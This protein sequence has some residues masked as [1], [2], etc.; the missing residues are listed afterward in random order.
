LLTDFRIADLLKARRDYAGALDASRE[1]LAVARRLSEK[2]PNNANWQI[3]IA[4]SQFNVGEAL[5]ALGDPKDALPAYQEA[6]ELTVALAD[7]EPGT[8]FWK[9][10]LWSM[11]RALGDTFA[12]LG[13]PS[14]ALRT[15][16]ESRAVAA[17]LI[18]LDPTNVAYQGDLKSSLD[19]VGLTVSTLLES[20]QFAQALAGLDAVPIGGADAAWFALLRA[21]CLMLLERPDEARDIFNQHRGEKVLGERTWADLVPEEF[22]RLRQVGLQHDLMDEVEKAIAVNP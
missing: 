8:V 6:R 21:E 17:A 7:K 14:S 22:A 15:Y 18:D 13:D 5:S 9:I 2:A 20:R 10:E 16:L 4:V 11:E 12:R 3:D 19:K 1:A